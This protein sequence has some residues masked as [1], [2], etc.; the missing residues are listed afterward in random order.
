YEATLAR[1]LRG[2][3]AKIFAS[4]RLQLER[5]R[6]PCAPAQ[7]EVLDARRARLTL[8]EGRYHQARRMFAAVGNHVETLHR[9]RVGGLTLGDL[10]AG[11]WRVLGPADLQQ[12]FAAES[13]AED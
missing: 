12:L 9:S 11:Q 10:P 2:D 8:T 4:G 3:E 13:P 5:E 6:E 7:L 1:D